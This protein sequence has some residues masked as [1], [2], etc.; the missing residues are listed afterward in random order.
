MVGRLK[1]IGIHITHYGLVIVLHDGA[2]ATSNTADF[3]GE[4][5]E[6]NSRRN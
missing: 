1:T 2:H 6:I 5:S 3:R 4:K